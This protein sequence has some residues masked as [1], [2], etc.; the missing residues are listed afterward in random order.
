MR[1]IEAELG[2]DAAV[3]LARDPRRLLTTYNRAANAAREDGRE[4]YLFDDALAGRFEAFEPR[5]EMQE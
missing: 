1:T 3:N 4:A 5:A 2:G